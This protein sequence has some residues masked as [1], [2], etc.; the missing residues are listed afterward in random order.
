MLKL[1][2]L[3]ALVLAPLMIGGVFFLPLEQF[4]LFI[5][6]IVTVGAWEW[7]NLSGIKMQVGRVAY[8]G[9]LA[10]LIYAV[11]LTDMVQEIELLYAAFIWWMVAFLLVSVHPKL[12]EY[13]S[14]P[15]VRMIM[16]LFILIPMWVGFVQIKSYPFNDYLIM[17]VMLIVWGADVGAYFAGR[18]F[19]KRKLAVTVSPGKTWE[20]VF[21]GLVVTT[22]IAFAGGRLLEHATEMTLSG[23]QWCLLIVITLSIT[24][25]SIVGDLI[26]S[27]I[28]RH[29]RIKDSS[30][31]LPGHGGIMD[32]IDSMTAALPMFA[33]ALSIFGWN[34]VV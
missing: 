2:I 14:S 22:L 10:G 12:K 27:M 23:S 4:K 1:R 24:A 34:L 16:G 21:G 31:L 25:V 5:G 30:N 19:G 28:K 17:F 7:A 9:L 18:M 32:R 6:F 26:E 15:V 33:L 13:W 3:T 8:A 20:G 29:R 11:E